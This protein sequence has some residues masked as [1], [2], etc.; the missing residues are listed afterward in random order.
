[1]IYTIGST[2]LAACVDIGRKPLDIDRI[3]PYKEVCELIKSIPNKKAVYPI[4]EGKKIIVKA[5]FIHEY[6]IAWPGSSAEMLIKIID[7][8]RALPPTTSS[9]PMYMCQKFWYRAGDPIFPPMEVLYALKMSHRYLRNSPHFLKTM[10]DIQLMREWG[11]A[12]K[13]QETGG[14][15]PALMDFYKLRMKETYWYNHPNLKTNKDEFFKDIYEY[16]HDSI[17]VAVKHLEKP[18]Y[19]YFKPENSEV[20]CDKDLFNI[21]SDKTKL[22]AVLEEAYVLALERSLIPHPGVKTPK[23][24]FDMALMKVCTSI[25]SGYFREWA[26]EHYDRVQGLYAEEADLYWKW[27]QIGIMNGTV[28]KDK[29]HE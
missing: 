9:N 26:W 4:N 28:R 10:K 19:Q 20:F 2:A 15:H 17:H 27:F 25:T 18:A 6:E 5:D 29:N 7:E 22:Y 1:M 8:D 13:H 11:V 23:Q 16:D 24:A 3:G 12:D 21:A 14:I